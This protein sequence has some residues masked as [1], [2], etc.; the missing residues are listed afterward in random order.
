VPLNASLLSGEPE[1]VV[2]RSSP[3]ETFR[4]L[5]GG[6]A[7]RGSRRFPQHLI[8]PHG[9]PRRPGRD[10]L[11]F[12]DSRQEILAASSGMLATPGL[13]WPD[14]SLP[15]A[16]TPAPGPHTSC[17]ENSITRILWLA[18]ASS[19]LLRGL[20]S[21]RSTSHWEQAQGLNL[22]RVRFSLTASW[23]YV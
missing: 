21:D 20:F 13:F 23:T 10:S 22:R 14:Q 17:L 11:S 9:I 3:K 7:F 12:L 4:W 19:G 1:A 16:S 8:L 18:S 6:A 2:L 15:A 5:G